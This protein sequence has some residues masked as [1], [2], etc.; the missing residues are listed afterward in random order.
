MTRSVSNS[1][2]KSRSVILGI[3]TS[4][5]ETAVALVSADGHVLA[6]KVR[7]QLTEHA[8]YGGVVPEIAARAHLQVLD[9][10]IADVMTAADVRF[11]DL[12]GIA[13]TAGPGL[14]GGVMVGAV[15]AKAIAAAAGKPFFAINHLEGH[16]LSPRLGNPQLAFPYLLLLVSGGHCQLLAVYGPGH[17]HRLGGTI[18]DAVG[19][20][21]DKLAKMLELGYPGGPLVEAAARNGRP[22][23]YD[24]PR[25]MAGRDGLDFSFSGLKSAAKRVIDALPPGPVEKQIAADLCRAFQDAV[26]DVL[27]DRAGAAMALLAGRAEGQE[28]PARLPV[29]SFFVVAGGVAAN[30]YLRARLHAVAGQQGYEFTAPPLKYCTDNAAMIGWAAQERRNAG[31][32]SDS[33]ATKVRPRWPLEAMAASDTISETISDNMASSDGPQDPLGY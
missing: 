32:P 7:T 13:A 5:D 9:R 25:P 29:G 19:E 1:A 30:Q 24:L 20:A 22:G 21:F 23:Q 3:E 11:D 8:P 4:C 12:A 2:A 31:L 14:I 16:A 15:T 17:Y 27:V 18:D 33:L 6:E 10:L 26:G 28:A